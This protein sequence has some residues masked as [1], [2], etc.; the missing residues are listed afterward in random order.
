[1]NWLKL[2]CFV[3]ANLSLDDDAG[4][5]ALRTKDIRFDKGILGAVNSA[6]MIAESYDKKLAFKLREIAIFLNNLTIGGG[7][8]VLVARYPQYSD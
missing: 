3:L 2:L 6:H 5:D 1:M 8:P 4:F 7:L